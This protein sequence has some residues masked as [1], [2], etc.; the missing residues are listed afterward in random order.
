MRNA[1]EGRTRKMGSIGSRRTG[2]VAVV[3]LLSCLAASTAQ[4]TMRV[5]QFSDAIIPKQ[6][7][8]PT[9]MAVDQETGDVY[10]GGNFFAAGVHKLEAGTEKETV[11]G[12]GNYESVAINP[13][14]HNIYALTRQPNPIRIEIYNQ[15]FETAHKPI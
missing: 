6:N 13:V 7:I 5:Y 11:F 1:I 15:E 14:N 3:A 12:E 4:A 9:G 8:V 2:V 10:V